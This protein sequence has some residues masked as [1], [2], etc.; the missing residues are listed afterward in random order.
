VRKDL[1]HFWLDES[2]WFRVAQDRNSGGLR[3]KRVSGH[4]LKRGKGRKESEEVDLLRQLALLH[5]WCATHVPGLLEESK[6]SL[7]T[8]ARQHDHAKMPDQIRPVRFK[9]CLPLRG[10]KASRTIGGLL[11]RFKVQVMNT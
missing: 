2:S 9:L 6:T 8:N 4:V 10:R 3:A 7:D 5:H 11:S 1:K